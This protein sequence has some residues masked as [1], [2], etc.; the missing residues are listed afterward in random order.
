MEK[1]VN[2]FKSSLTMGAV[3]IEQ[4]LIPRETGGKNPTTPAS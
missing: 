1:S 2:L 3:F 4:R